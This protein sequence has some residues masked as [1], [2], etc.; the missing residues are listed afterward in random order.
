MNKTI[1]LTFCL[2]SG[3]ALTAA[4]AMDLKQSKITQVVNDVQIIS[5]SDQQ[6]RRPR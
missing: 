6:K 2:A 3:C 1:L 4:H 5:A